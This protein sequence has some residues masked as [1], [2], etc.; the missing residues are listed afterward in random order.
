MKYFILLSFTLFTLHAMSLQESIDYAL[1]HNNS[2]KQTELKVQSSKK[3]RD[4]KHAQKFGKVDV[5]A[6]YD[7]YNLSRTLAPLTPMS[8]ASSEDASY[9]IPTTQDF[10][11]TGVSYNVVL[12]NGY[13]QQSS[14]K[15]SDL[16]Y[17]NSTIRSK[18]GREE[19]IYNV[20]NLYLS[21]LALEEQL[22]AQILY[23]ESEKRVLSKIEKQSI[24]PQE[25]QTTFSKSLL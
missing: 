17:Q 23:T 22:Q 24:L 3:Q 21:T 13:E 19:L 15:I 4:A 12:F 16:M 7:H 1:A 2:L 25:N 8:L 10:F 18:L 11:S 9:K 20:R 6:S 5:T 14:Y